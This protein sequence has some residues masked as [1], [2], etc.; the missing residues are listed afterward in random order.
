MPLAA[1]LPVGVPVDGQTAPLLQGLGIEPGRFVLSLGT[2]EPRKNYTRLLSAFERL[3]GADPG[4]RLSSW[5]AGSG[6]GGFRRA[7]DRSPIRDRV[8]LAG[9]LAD[10]YVAGLLRS[11]A[12]MA[13]PSLYEGFGLPVLE[14]MA[15]GAPVVTSAASALPETAGGAAVL[16]DPSDVGSIASGLA[17]AMARADEL[18]AAGLVRAGSRTWLDVGLETLDVYRRAAG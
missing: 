14:A 16:V 18:C 4:L 13:Y 9:P 1:R 12:V 7:L 8:V 2:I 3:V 5:G 17:D 10:A 15:A 11:C 6:F